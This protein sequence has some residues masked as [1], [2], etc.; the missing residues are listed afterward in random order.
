MESAEP[1]RTMLEDPFQ[2]NGLLGGTE[3]QEPEEPRTAREELEMMSSNGL[4]DASMEDTEVFRRLGEEE[5]DAPA[6]GERQLEDS[7]RQEEEIGE[8]MATEEFSGNGLLF[9]GDDATQQPETPA[10]TTNAESTALTAPTNAG[11]LN[12]EAAAVQEEFQ[13]NGILGGDLAMDDEPTPSGEAVT[14]PTLPSV[15]AVD[16]FEANGLLGDPT[17]DTEDLN[18]TSAG[19]VAGKSTTH[20]ADETR[21]GGSSLDDLLDEL[22]SAGYTAAEKGKGRAADAAA[23]GRVP[24]RSAATPRPE[25]ETPTGVDLFPG[26]NLV[27]QT[28]EVEK[29]QPLEAVDGRG[30]KVVFTRRPRKVVDGK[31]VSPSL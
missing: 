2:S 12:P 16:G 7:V 23:A 18:P 14:V 8:K 4:L 9:G 25:A 15:T 22:D 1:P 17:P 27:L 28:D 11:E 21:L 30:R 19:S 13:G 29:L 20:T 26:M 10:Q 6:V 24:S 3:M 5:T 31:G